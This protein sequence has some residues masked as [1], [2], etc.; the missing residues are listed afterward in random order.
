MQKPKNQRPKIS[1]WL[2]LASKK[3]AKQGLNK[4]ALTLNWP[5]LT[6][7]DTTS[8]IYII[9]LQVV[10]KKRKQN[11]K[12]KALIGKIGWIFFEAL[13]VFFMNYFLFKMLS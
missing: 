6:S 1:I 10:K 9:G 11:K 2:S 4:I 13:V 3:F 12:L 7:G 8:Q 5:E